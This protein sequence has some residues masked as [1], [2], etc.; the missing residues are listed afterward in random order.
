MKVATTE[1][2]SNEATAATSGAG[3]TRLPRIWP[4]VEQPMIAVPG[5]A[6]PSSAIAAPESTSGS[7]NT[8]ATRNRGCASTCCWVL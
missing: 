4:A 2:L 3:S 6:V 1:A 7:A 8:K 5:S